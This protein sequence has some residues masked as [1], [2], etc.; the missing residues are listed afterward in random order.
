MHDDAA[1]EDGGD[2]DAGDGDAGDGDAGDGDAGDGDGDADAGN[3][4][5]DVVSALGT[6]VLAG[7]SVAVALAP[8][9]HRAR[10][11][12]VVPVGSGAAPAA[13]ARPRR[14]GSGRAPQLAC[15]CAGLGLALLIGG[16]FGALAGLLLALAGP[17]GL[18]RLEPRS[19][20]QDRERFAADLPLA[21]DLL[22]ACLAGGAALVP[23]LRVVAEAVSGPC[24]L[25]LA[26]VAAALDVGS[27]PQ[28][29]WGR[30]SAAADEELAGQAARAL[31]RAG[32]GGAPVAGAVAQLAAQARRASR[33]RGEQ[34]A[35]RAGVLA[36]APLGLCF[37]PAFVLIGIVPVVAG[38][39][40]PVLAGL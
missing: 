40:G 33:A 20:R 18:A 2:G 5:A 39:V 13:V 9:Q 6:A 38:L 15:V 23:A 30:L 14:P 34:A 3:G 11:A 24:G 31:A 19:V 4:D 36:V 1:D 27:P 26:L 21:L 28:E 35:Q 17:T 10:L 37:L 7:L 25:R 8:A 32:E 16:V 29:A 22:A 12:A